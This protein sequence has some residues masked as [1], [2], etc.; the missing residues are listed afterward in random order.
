MSLALLLALVV[1]GILAALYVWRSGPRREAEARRVE[2]VK[3]ADAELA[4]E[5]QA[6]E[7][8]HGD[9]VEAADARLVEART[10]SRTQRAAALVRAAKGDS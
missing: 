9:A 7:A 1:A 4:T 3:A 6:I 2:E 5:T 8:R 10:R